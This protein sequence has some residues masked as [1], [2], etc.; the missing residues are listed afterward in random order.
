MGQAMN[1]QQRP[2]GQGNVPVTPDARETLTRYREARERMDRAIVDARKRLAEAQ[3]W[4]L[5]H[6]NS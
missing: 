6:R 1:K 3:K 4:L 2:S 5:A